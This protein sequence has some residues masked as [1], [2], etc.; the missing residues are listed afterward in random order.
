MSSST[1]RFR[2]HILVIRLSALGDVAILQ[3]VVR[4]WAAANPETL[5]TIA[6]P[7]ILQP[8]FDKT[9]NIRFLPTQKKQSPIKIY[10]HLASVHPT[11]VA[12]MHWVNRSIAVDLLFLM[13]GT[14]LHHIDKSRA[15][16]R[17]LTH[18][19]AVKYNRQLRPSW[20]RY[21]DVFRHL[22]LNAPDQT[23][24]AESRKYWQPRLGTPIRIGIAPFA[25]HKGK[26]WPAE[27][28]KQLIALLSHWQDT[29]IMLFGSRNEASTLEQWAEPYDNVINTAGKQTF[30]QELHIIA[31]LSLMI[32]MDSAN[33]HF[34]SCL[35]IPVVSIWGATHPSGGFAGWRQDP[36]NAVQAALP[37]RPCSM[38][39][40]KE[41]RFADYRCLYQI[42]PQAVAERVKITL[43]IL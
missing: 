21:D 26:I 42:T 34:A 18:F 2:Q 38:Y 20:Q 17:R 41:C 33:M 35:G 12:D 31:S 29:E 14:K 27:K 9:D 10:K 28:M 6:A 39:G 16:R 32:S 1:S 36:D 8:L 23:L 43:G 40:K 24:E 7:P 13:H 19:G 11:A 25:Q 3:P 15:E 37:C 4:Q 22:G 5:F 30:E